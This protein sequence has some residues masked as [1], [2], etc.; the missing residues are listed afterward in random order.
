MFKT[1]K[2]RLRNGLQLHSREHVNQYGLQTKAKQNL[3]IQENLKCT[4]KKKK[5]NTNK[6][7]NKI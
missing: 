7:T 2:N 5:N 1:Q 4:L 3:G 6:K